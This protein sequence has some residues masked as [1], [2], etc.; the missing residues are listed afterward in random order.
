MSPRTRLLLIAVFLLWPLDVMAQTSSSAPATGQHQL[1]AA[2]LDALIAPI[3]LY[4]DNLLS[5]VLMA[6]TFPLEVVHAER[7]L[8]ANKKLTGDQLED[9]VA[10]QDW[11]DSIKSLVATPSVLE[12]M[13]TKL[14]WTQKLGN[15][16]VAQQP[17]IMDAIQ[18][19]RAKAQANNALQSTK[20]QKVTVSQ[21]QGRQ[22]I[23]IA[24]TDPD[25]V[26]VPYY[27]PAVVYGA[28]PYPAYPP[29]YW[30]PPG[31]IAGGIIATG[32]AFGAGYALGRWASG[33]YWGGSVNWSNNNIT[34]N[35]P[36]GGGGGNW[37]RNA[38]VEHRGGNR[39][40]RQL[41]FRGRN[42]QQV[43]N[44][45][46]NR[47]NLGGGNLGNR[48]STRPAG[49][50]R[51]ER[52]NAGNRQ[53]GNRVQHHRAGGG[54][55]ANLRSHA[56]HRAAGGGGHR[57]AIGG[58]GHRGGGGGHRA[59][60]GGGHRGGGGGGHRAGGGGHRGGGGGGRGGGG[61]R[62]DIRLK[63]DIVLVGRLSDGLG[64]YRFV[65][66]GGHKAYVGVIA[67][68]VQQVV[69]QAVERGSD[70]YLRVHYGQLGLKFES[71]QRWI[72]SGSRPPKAAGL[73]L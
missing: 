59:L 13:S 38:H 28:W 56:G 31:Y 58:G 73:G 23:A 2:E 5:Q 11:D 51:G 54:G 69:P 44:P 29:Y 57:A 71:Y 40:N 41:D 66:N 4:P 9:A 22:V 10:K 49:G 7:W 70:G 15:A 46:G 33:G 25:T 63:H 30:P 24:P 67:Q 52:V 6:S 36:G 43:L 12:M 47:G 65:Y 16:V 42:G 62:S 3:A 72:K 20:E 14:D 53:G 61:R 55:A 17:D 35:R 21:S 68:E 34:V 39:G 18:R 60:G 48:P 27:N 64:V 50:N 37:N 45:G 8:Q 32:I 19:L 1:S 26:Y